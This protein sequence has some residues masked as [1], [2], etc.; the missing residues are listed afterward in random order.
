MY[1]KTTKT[2]SWQGKSDEFRQRGGWLKKLMGA[3][4]PLTVKPH[5]SR[6]GTLGEGV[7]GRAEGFSEV[8]D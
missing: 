4:L 2:H 5:F 7:Q 8:G 1:V 3:D 6:G